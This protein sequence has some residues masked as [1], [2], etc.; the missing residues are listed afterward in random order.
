MPNKK[1]DDA[2]FADI[3]DHAEHMKSYDSASDTMYTSIDEM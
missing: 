2:L 3:K 1:F